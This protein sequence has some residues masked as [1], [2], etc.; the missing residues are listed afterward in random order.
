MRSLQSE[1]LMLLMDEHVSLEP[2]PDISSLLEALKL[3]E[4]RGTAGLLALESMHD[5]RNPLEAL[6]NLIFLAKQ[7]AEYPDRVREY[8]HLAEQQMHS[9]ADITRQALGFARMA[10]NDS[11]AVLL[12]IAEA[13]L[14]LHQRKIDQKK[15][16]LIKDFHATASSTVSRG[17]MLQVISN[18]VVNAIDALP[19]NG[20]LRVRVRKGSDDVRVT[21]ADNGRGIPLEHHE[22]IFQPFFTTKVGYGTGLGLSLSK[23]ILDRYRG[24]IRM[25]SSIL[26]GRSGT[27]F[28]ISLPLNSEAIGA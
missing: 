28:R 19:R 15:I 26:P 25:R 20:T 4:T 10:E 3:A 23:R 9:L 6:S 1:G 21:I 11:S 24:R 27:I 8:L 7:E 16:R 12:P 13:A 22:R 2:Q 5:I 17:E 14:R 18:L